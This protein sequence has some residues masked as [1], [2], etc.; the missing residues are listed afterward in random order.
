[1]AIW[2]SGLDSGAETRHSGKLTKIR[3]KSKVHLVVINFLVFDKYTIVIIFG[4]TE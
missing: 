3:I 1:M 2:Y 4:K